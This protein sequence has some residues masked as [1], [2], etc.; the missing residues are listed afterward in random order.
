MRK[1]REVLR[2]SAAGHG[3]RAIAQSVRIGRSTVGDC[4]ARARVAGVC[5]PTDLDD[6]ALERTLYPPRPP[7][8]S[9]SR[10]MPE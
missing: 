6:A 10:S 9:A 4:L 7:M 3:Q 1:I 8:P 5:W 2:L